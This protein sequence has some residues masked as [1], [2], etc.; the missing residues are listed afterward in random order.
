MA[1]DLTMIVA[2][3]AVSTIGQERVRATL[4]FRDGRDP[5]QLPELSKDE[6]ARCIVA[7]LPALLE[8][9]ST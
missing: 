5:L 7:E 1:K 3:D 6:A 8:G 4:L 2:N 9:H